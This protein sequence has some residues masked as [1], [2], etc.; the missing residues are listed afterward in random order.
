M[1]KEDYQSSCLDCL[2]VVK[3]CFRNDFQLILRISSK[4]FLKL[5]STSK[6]FFDYFFSKASKPVIESILLRKSD[7]SLS[8]ETSRTAPSESDL[9]NARHWS[10][11]ADAFQRSALCK[12]IVPNAGH[13]IWN[14]DA[15][16]RN[17]LSEGTVLN[18]GDWI[19]DVDA[20]QRCAQTKGVAPNARYWI[21]DVDA[22]QR[23]ALCKGIA[24]YARL[25]TDCYHWDWADHLATD[26]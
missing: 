24:P 19:W 9:P 8:K 11:D 7:T 2:R 17:A 23:L 3:K 15:F 13:W 5:S 12:C 4:S 1:S 26:H 18:A 14:V 22:F 25:A 10:R 21:W 20:F 16:Q 6:V